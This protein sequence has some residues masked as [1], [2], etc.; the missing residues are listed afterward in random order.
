MNREP[1]ATGTA[2]EREE[3][4]R[5]FIALRPKLQRRLNEEAD[6]GL[7]DELEELTIHQLYVLD[8]LRGGEVPMREL[9]RALGIKESSATS[10]VDRLVRAGFAARSSEPADRRLVLVGLTA[11]GEAA[12]DRVRQATCRRMG[13]ML[14]PLSDDQMRTLVEI[15]ESLANTPQPSR[16]AC[17]GHQSQDREGQDREAQDREGQP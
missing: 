10:A 7:H 5:R 3:L 4:V 17:R 16:P 12:V 2:P 1:A 6:R 14:A 8:H 11:A 13:E 15:F 9:A